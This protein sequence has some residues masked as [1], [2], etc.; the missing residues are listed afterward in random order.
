MRI[1]ILTLTLT[2]KP[3]PNPNLKLNFKPN[4][5]PDA[6]AMVCAL[7]TLTKSMLFIALFVPCS[8]RKLLTFAV[9]TP[10]PP[11]QPE[12]PSS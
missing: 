1:L 5:A 7:G 12:K 11:A 2:P 9:L 6:D 4:P 3:Y 10:E 8:M